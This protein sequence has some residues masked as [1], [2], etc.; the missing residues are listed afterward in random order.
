VLLMLFPIPHKIKAANLR[1]SF[2]R[3]LKKIL[4]VSSTFV[5]VSAHTLG[6]QDLTSRVAD[7]MNAQVEVNHFR[8]SILIAQ[9][10]KVLVTKRYGPEIGI[11]DGQKTFNSR[12]PLGSIAKQFIAAAILQLQEKGKLQLQDSVCKY[13][14]KCPNGWEEIKIFNLLVQTDG[15]PEAGRSLDLTETSSTTTTPELLRYLGGLPLAFKPGERF[16]YGNSGYAVLG[17]VIEKVSGEPYLKYL[18]DHIF[19]PLGMNETGE[20]DAPQKVPDIDL[21]RSGKSN[22]ITPNDMELATRYSWGR[23][24]STVEDLYRWDRA[25]DDEV[26]LS[27]KSRNAMFTPYI[28][29][30][31]FGWVILKEFE[32]T[33]DTQAGKIYLFESSIRRYAN[34]DVCVIVLSNSDNADAG[35]ISRDLAAI[36]FGKHYELPIEHHVINLNPAIY[37]S[38]AGRYEL[39]SDFVLVVSREGDRLMIQSSGQPKVEIFPESET[40]FF[41]EGLDTVINF[42]KNPQGN[43]AQLVL[44]QGGREIPALRTK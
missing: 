11:S 14:A 38:Y 43:A 30:Y 22:S 17:A 19:I 42:V 2:R 44:Q 20:D 3:G 18:K 35:R 24:Y 25:L 8:G 31:G 41:A 4:L 23:L 37:D 26:L 9:H 21:A 5:L 34:E 28:D 16:R 10:G 39:A 32:R 7:Y 29:G 6:A 36:L 1:L 33:L 15:I 12:Y 13:I 40:R 27:K